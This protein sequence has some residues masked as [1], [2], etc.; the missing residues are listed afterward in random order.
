M[1]ELLFK[2][3]LE[4]S[5]RIDDVVKYISKMNTKTKIGFMLIFTEAYIIRKIVKENSAKI[6]S[7]E[8]ELK[9]MKSKGE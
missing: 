4:N 8:N 6:E 9:E 1:I 5:G 3:V 7:L 2:G